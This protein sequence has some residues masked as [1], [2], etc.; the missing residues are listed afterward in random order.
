MGV[1]GLQGF[2]GSTCPQVCTVVNLRELAERHRSRHPACTPTVVVDAMCCLRYWYT[3]ES[4]VCGGQWREY[5]SALRDFVKA[6][7]AAG[8]R[9]VFF[10]DGMVE[11]GK[12]E[13]WVTRRRK[14]NREIA[15]IFQHV[16]ARRAQPG[17]SMFFIPAGLAVFTR[18]ALQG[19]GQETVCSLREADYEAAAYGLRPG[20]LGV[21]G[22]DTD[23]LIYDTCP[24]LSAG[25]L[26]LERLETLMLCRAELCA[27]LR[28]RPADLPLLA[29]LL[30]NDVVPEGLF[31]GF[32]YRCL[33]AYTAAREGPERRGSAI[34]AVA[35]HIA[36]VLHAHQGERPLDELLPLG[37]H[38]ALFYRGLASYLLP[39][40]QSPWLPA[41]PAGGA[42][43]PALLEAPQETPRE[44]EQETPREAPQETPQEARLL[45]DSDPALPSPAGAAPAELD[46]RA[47]PEEP[48][49]A[50]QEGQPRAAPALD[51]DILKVRGRA[52]QPVRAPGGGGQLPTAGPSPLDPA[53][54][55]WGQT[56]HRARLPRA[57]C[58]RGA[59]FVFR[60]PG[61]LP[62]PAQAS[63][64]GTPAAGGGWG[65]HLRQAPGL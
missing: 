29:C 60:D 20:C 32:R 31:E 55:R 14:N 4:W 12:R 5:F 58:L 47:A 25:E 33:A 59:A 34:L 37:A 64:L 50:E 21:L 45:A 30:G 23:Y 54:V 9:L 13:E 44:A 65:Q 18:F 15:R 17:R 16:K 8:I 26:R 52:R 7:A 3:P 6:F 22:E 46:A 53:V 43:T 49:N 42:S 27:A 38:A 41:A 57:L 63:L 35:D 39:G 28:L 19:L 40:Q 24:Y 36:R 62:A 51:P 1:R 61:G 11:P 2:I 10:F 56:D 48:W